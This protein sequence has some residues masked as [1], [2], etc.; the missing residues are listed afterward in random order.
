VLLSMM[1][2]PPEEWEKDWLVMLR[3]KSEDAG[4]IAMELGSSGFNVTYV[5]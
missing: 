1:T 3:V 4:P 5:G 2:L